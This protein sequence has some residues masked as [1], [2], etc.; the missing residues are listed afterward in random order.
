MIRKYFSYYAR[1]GGSGLIKL[2]SKLY[3]SPEELH[4]KIREER[5]QPWFAI[6]GDK[7]LR[8]IYNLNRNSIVFDLGGYEG[9][10]ASDI[11]SMYQCKVFIFEPVTEFFNKIKSR[12]KQNENIFVYN[13]GLSSKNTKLQIAKCNDGS[14]IFN[15]KG[16]EKEEIFLRNILEF[17]QEHNISAID[18]IKINIEGAEYDLLEHLI[19]SNFITNIIN[20]QIQFHDFVPDAEVRMKAIQEKL[21]KTHHLT[22]QFP[23]VWE[24]WVI[25]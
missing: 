7:T 6:N 9:Q 12:F 25:G 4:N 20:L 21:A 11:F 8:L 14:S 17:L 3:Q 10:W 5:A 15:E 24:N 13:Y 18:L 23:Y 1:K 22:Y 2:S 19:Q 16:C